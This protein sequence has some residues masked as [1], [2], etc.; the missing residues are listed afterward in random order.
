MSDRIQIDNIRLV[1]GWH[2]CPKCKCVPAERMVINKNGKFY[3]VSCLC[4][5]SGEKETMAEAFAEWKK[6]VEHE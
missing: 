1:E 3:E 2:R 5:E 4:V 6:K